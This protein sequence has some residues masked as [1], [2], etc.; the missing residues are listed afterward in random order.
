MD[1]GI[2]SDGEVL[3]TESGT[4]LSNFSVRSPVLYYEA[5]DETIPGVLRLSIL[6]YGKT[7]EVDLDVRAPSLV[8]QIQQMCPTCKL[9]QPR[10]R[11]TI[12]AH[13]L[14]LALTSKAQGTKPPLCFRRHG[15]HRLGDGN[16]AFVAGD[17]LL[18]A[19]SG[20]AYTILPEVARPHLA[21]SKDLTCKEAVR[22][23][24]SALARNWEHMLPLWAFT[25]ASSMRSLLCTANLTTFPSL[26]VIGG[27]GLGKTTACQRFSLLYDDT[28]RPGR[29]WAEVD[30]K[31]TAAS[32][33]DATLQM[34]RGPPC[35]ERR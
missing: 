24:I 4:P 9:L 11:S 31:S 17:E 2:T 5:D 23:L 1:Y 32:T 22:G 15:F 27:Q 18:G 28:Q 12:D 20:R 33:V 3:T 34:G 26:A 6:H 21:Y 10:M 29:R 13:L 19:L 14:D 30:A 7:H 25:L 16:Y 8:S 35:H